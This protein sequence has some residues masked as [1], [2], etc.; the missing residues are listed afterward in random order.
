MN[1]YFIIL[2]V[3]TNQHWDECSAAVSK[4]TY[5][6]SEPEENFGIQLT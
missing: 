2:Q 5:K 3:V 6:G 4:E 1:Q